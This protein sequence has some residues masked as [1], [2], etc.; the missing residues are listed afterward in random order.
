MTPNPTQAN[1][2]ASLRSFLTAVLPATGVDGN[3][4]SVVLGQINRVPEVAGTDFVIMSPLR[5]ERIETNVDSYTD[6]VFTGSI[7]GATMTITA[8]DPRAF[9]G[10]IA[11]GSQMFGAGLAAGTKVTALGTGTGG[12]GTYTVT[13][14]QTVGSEKLSC[15]T[16]QIQQATR[17]AIQLDFHSSDESAAADMAQTVTTLFRDEYAVD[18]FAN[19]SPNYGVVPLLAD[20]ARQLPFFN[21]QSQTEWRWVVEALLQANVVVTI[22]QEFADSV[23]LTT[24]DVDAA[25]AP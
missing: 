10:E 25:Y 9:P 8:V 24:I 19:Q 5:Q 17:F 2:L 13:P 16:Q 7:A 23:K 15:G 11:V 4:V 21:D 22:S 6:A 1:V 3:P 20:D 14:S 12:I 18:Q